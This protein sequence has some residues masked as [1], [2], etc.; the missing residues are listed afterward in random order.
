MRA[1]RSGSIIG[2]LLLAC[3]PQSSTPVPQDELRGSWRMTEHTTTVDSQSVTYTNPQPSLF[4]FAE[5]DHYSMMY[6]PGEQ[7]R[8]MFAVPSAP[9][10]S[11][12]VAAYEPFVA[13]SGRYA[14]VGDTVVI[15]P[16]VAKNPNFMAGD[17]QVIALRLLGDTLWLTTTGG[18]AATG[19]VRRLERVR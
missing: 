8:I 6:V 18:F 14:R 4:I 13:N 15:H 9:T 3:A 2:L 19:D 11:E 12:M 17:S 5:Q 10:D 16:I 7:P 1:S